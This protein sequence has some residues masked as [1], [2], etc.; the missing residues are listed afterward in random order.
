MS[1]GNQEFILGED[2]VFTCRKNTTQHAM[3]YFND[4]VQ[5]ETDHRITNTDLVS[6]LTIN[7]T[8]NL[9]NTHIQCSTKDVK[10]NVIYIY[11][12]GK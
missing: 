2:I 12:E 7:L 5:N 10:S 11:I 9:N 6:L 8:M 1:R 3:W 4:T